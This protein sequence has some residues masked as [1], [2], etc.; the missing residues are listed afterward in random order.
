MVFILP[1]PLDSVI[2]MKALC[3]VLSLDA[4]Q[5]NNIEYKLNNFKTLFSNRTK[6]KISDSTRTRFNA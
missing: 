1:I 4:P 3:V 2:Y 6:V 5:L